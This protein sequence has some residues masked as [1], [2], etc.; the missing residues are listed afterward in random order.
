VPTKNNRST[1][2]QKNSAAI[3][4]NEQIYSKKWSF[5]LLL[6]TNPLSY[7]IIHNIA[8]RGCGYWLPFAIDHLTTAGDHH[9][10]F[11]FFG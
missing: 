11:N 7:T 2:I 4:Q 8:M 5:A 9:G 1:N 10:D 6:L 3:V